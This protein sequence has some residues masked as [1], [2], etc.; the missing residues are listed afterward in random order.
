MKKEKDWV[1]KAN[2]RK[3]KREDRRIVDFMKITHHFFRNSRNGSMSWK[4]QGIHLILLIHRG[5]LS[6]WVC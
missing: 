5:I 2:K 4:I 6:G 1:R 3:K